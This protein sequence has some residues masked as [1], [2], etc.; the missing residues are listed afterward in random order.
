[1]IK[2]ILSDI[3][4]TLI[5][6]EHHI[7][8]VN[9]E[10][11]NEARKLGVKFALCTGRSPQYCV[12]IMKE[13]GIYG[14][15]D[16]YIIGFNGALIT[17]CRDFKPIYYDQIGYDLAK[18]IFDYGRQTYQCMIVFQREKCFLFN[19]SPLELRRKIKQ[20]AHFEV[21]DDTD[22]SFLK[23]Q[24]VTKIVFSNPNP[25]QLNQIKED[26]SARLE[27]KVNITFSS[28]RYIE[29][30]ALNIDKGVGLQR[31]AKMLDIPLEMTMAIGDNEN[32]VEML[33]AANIGVAVRSATANAKRYASY[34]TALDYAD[35]AV[36]EA[37]ERFVLGKIG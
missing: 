11:I 25:S 28:G 3:D 8:K 26:M 23:G 13:L 24:D 17:N 30:N 20:S 21:M 5:D 31:L 19:P 18:E 22:L 12:N 33:Q 1:M 9:L 16:E 15:D 7:P 10:R 27:G 32:D 14:R 35:G 34:I 6:R 2:L 36:A 37:I 4:E 29:F